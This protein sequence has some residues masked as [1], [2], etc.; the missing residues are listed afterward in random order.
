MYKFI[1]LV[2]LAI[3]ISNCKHESVEQQTVDALRGKWEIYEIRSIDSQ[4]KEVIIRK[5]E[6]LSMYLLSPWYG[7]DSGIDFINA[8][9]CTVPQKL[10]RK[11]AKS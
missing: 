7:G 10:D 3:S 11:R 4:T 2:C 1:T 9:E 5:N 6:R 8:T